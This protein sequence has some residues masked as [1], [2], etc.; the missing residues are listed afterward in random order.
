[1]RISILTISGRDRAFFEREAN[2]RRIVGRDV[3]LAQAQAAHGTTQSAPKPKSKPSG[4]KRKA[5][6]PFS[7]STDEE[8]SASDADR[9]PRQRRRREAPVSESE[10][11]SEP[12]GDFAA[13]AG[14]RSSSPALR[15]QQ[16][17]PDS[18]ADTDTTPASSQRPSS[19]HVHA[20]KDGEDAR[21]GVDD[22]DAAMSSE[23]HSD[24]DK[25]NAGPPA[26]SGAPKRMQSRRA[27]VIDSDSDD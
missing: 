11:A 17:A 2:L 3:E 24:S 18:E 26:S 7:D 13:L 6:G 27:L 10:S 21:R 12:E 4:R 1:M 23:A 19:G 14:L 25:E 22:E 8:S 15:V 16:G 20:D 5:P 9:P